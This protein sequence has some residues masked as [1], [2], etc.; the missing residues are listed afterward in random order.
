MNPFKRH[1][2]ST[3]YFPSYSIF[4]LH[5]KRSSLIHNAIK[6]RKSISNKQRISSSMD[7][8]GA[9]VEEALQR[10]NGEV[11]KSCER[12]ERMQEELVTAWSGRGAALLP[13]RRDGGG[14]RRPGP[15]I[16]ASI[17]LRC[18]CFTNLL[19]TNL[20]LLEICCNYSAFASLA[21]CTCS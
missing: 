11:R 13:P 16:H 14:G 4:L 1:F 5:I 12:E 17:M 19:F 8:M 7:L 10:R 21:I 18:I 15:R 3:T 6:S 20:S 2:H 9:K